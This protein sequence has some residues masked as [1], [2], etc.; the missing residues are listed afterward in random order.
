VV[1]VSDDSSLGHP[2]FFS[3]RSGATAIALGKLAR[4]FGS[5]LLPTSVHNTTQYLVYKE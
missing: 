4:N 1:A 5:S 2:L 3:K